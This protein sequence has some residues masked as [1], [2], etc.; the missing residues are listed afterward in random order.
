MH[1]A[2]SRVRAYCH[3]VCVPVQSR[4]VYVRA[5]R[6]RVCVGAFTSRAR[7]RV[8]VCVSVRAVRSRVCVYSHVVCVCVCVRARMHAILHVFV[9][10]SV[11]GV[12]MGGP[13]PPL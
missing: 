8:C 12:A 1:A 5:I 7:A 11:S 2:T 6:S 13:R 10:V 3:V 9:C 4:C